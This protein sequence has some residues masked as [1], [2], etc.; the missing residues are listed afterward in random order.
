MGS[1][2]ITERK[3]KNR[4]RIIQG[5]KKSQQNLNKKI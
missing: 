3:I 1:K 4:I 5:K 2:I